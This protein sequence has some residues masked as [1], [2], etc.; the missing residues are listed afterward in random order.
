MLILCPVVFCGD[1]SVDAVL[2]A[3]LSETSR[4][5]CSLF[6]GVRYVRWQFK[7]FIKREVNNQYN[8]YIITIVV[9][10]NTADIVILY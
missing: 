7:I 6:E 5:D 10:I 2:A 9:E 4:Y 3:L 8:Y 1:V